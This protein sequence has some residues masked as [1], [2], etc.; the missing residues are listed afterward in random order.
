[1]INCSIFGSLSIFLLLHCTLARLNFK[2][3]GLLRTPDPFR[4]EG[5]G[6]CGDPRNEEEIAVAR[7]PPDPFNR[8]LKRRV[9]FMGMGLHYPAPLTL[10][11]NL[12]SKAR[13][14]RW[15]LEANFVPPP[16]HHEEPG[17]KSTTPYSR[18]PSY[19]NNRLLGFLTIEY[20][21]PGTYYLGTWSPIGLIIPD[22]PK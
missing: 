16:R 1:M 17:W 2:P 22:N 5:F 15:E 11:E 8:Q 18:A 7:R 12:P 6:L 21:E 10:Q 3:V 14:S 13:E 20:M 4:E 9:F 19:Q